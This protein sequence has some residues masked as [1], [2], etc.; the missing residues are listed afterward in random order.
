MECGTGVEVGL[1]HRGLC[2]GVPGLQ[3]RRRVKCI[4]GAGASGGCF[5]GEAGAL[6]DCFIRVAWAS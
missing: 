4:E 1:G 2:V 5:E 3:G 6:G